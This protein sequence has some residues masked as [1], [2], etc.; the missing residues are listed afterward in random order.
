MRGKGDFE[1]LRLQMVEKQLV[2]RGIRAER[3]L[4]AFRTVPRDLF[5]PEKL[6]SH[7]YEDHPLSI[8]FDQTISQPYMVAFMTEH[9]SLA[10]D[11]KILEIGTGSGYQTAILAGL[12]RS[13]YTIERIR[14][15]STRARET[16]E[17]LGYRNIFFKCGNGAEGWEEQA[18]FD[19]ILVSCAGSVAP[20]ALLAQLKEEGLMMMPLGGLISQVLTLFRKHSGT[21][22]SRALSRCAFVP[23]IE[24]EPSPHA[25]S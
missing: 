10:P 15:L 8:G 4:E 20:Q 25:A 1:R 21:I 18:P 6:T 5:V 14:E 3:I 2:R 17:A 16:L 11:S 12:S 13:V 22:E 7:A 23:L 19:R 24:K 9:L